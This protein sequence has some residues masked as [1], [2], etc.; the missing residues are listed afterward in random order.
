VSRFRSFRGRREEWSLLPPSGRQLKLAIV[1]AGGVVGQKLAE[2]LQERRFPVKELRLLATA[3]TAGS[4]L[5]FNGRELPI[6]LAEPERL[7]GLDI[8]FFAA[9]ADVSLRLAPEA[10]RRG[11]VAIDKSSAFREDPE[12]PL[13][14]PEVNGRV[15]RGHR[16]IIAS[17]NCST[18]QMVM[19]LK[20]LEDLSPLKR[21]IVSTYQSV[22]GTGREAVD[23]LRRQS[24]DVLDGRPVQA[25]VYPRQIAFNLLPHVDDF[26]DGGYSKEEMK[27]V[28]ETRKILGRP[29]L[30]VAATTVRVPV[31]VGHS[32]A[33]WIETER[34]ISP[35]EARAALARMPG[36]VVEDDPLRGV[37]P[38]PVDAAGRDE[39][40]V[41]RIRRDLTSDRGLVFWVV[42]DN[43][44]KGAAS[45]A[46]QIA[47]ALLE[48][49]LL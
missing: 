35:A 15:L 13:V 12:V 16:G 8:V 31:E 39:V 1:G 20:P 4:S 23:E 32:E 49:G 25:R 42:S 26:T 29:D 48:G 30:A 28:S 5:A 46:I 11:A 2:L 14:V 21:V 38:T 24:R 33:I 10:V 40:F 22:S 47:E 37:Y 34:P 7:D 36:V 41:G 19:V 6:E 18:I 17:P 27:M 43:L 9:P 3:R 44:R 45:N